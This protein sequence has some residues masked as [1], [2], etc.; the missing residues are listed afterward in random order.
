MPSIYLIVKTKSGPLLARLVKLNFLE[1]FDCVTEYQQDQTGNDEPNGIG[2]QY[3]NQTEFGNDAQ[4]T[5]NDCKPKSKFLGWGK[6]HLFL[7]DQIMDKVY[8]II[9]IF[10]LT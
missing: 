1:P 5:E 9:C 7:L 6:S 10:Q 8:Q 3:S 4:S 2:G